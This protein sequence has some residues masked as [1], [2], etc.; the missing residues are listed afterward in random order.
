LKEDYLIDFK[1]Q[2]YFQEKI[3]L[4]QKRRAEE[5][6]EIIELANCPEILKQGCLIDFRK[7]KRN[8]V[9]K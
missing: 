3:Y 7:E 9:L 4:P 6:I 5:C 8:N 1:S 2:T